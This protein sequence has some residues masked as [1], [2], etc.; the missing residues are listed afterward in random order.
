M[1]FKIT[2]D[3]EYNQALRFFKHMCLKPEY[4]GMKRV[5]KTDRAKLLKEIERFEDED[6]SD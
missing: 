5:K 1:H 4:G 2:S 6:G 3:E